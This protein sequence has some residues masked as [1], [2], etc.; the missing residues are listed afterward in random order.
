MRRSATWLV[1]FSGLAIALVGAVGA[2]PASA[3]PDRA[4]AS[5]V[6]VVGV[7]GLRWDDVSA[8]RTPTLTR[9]A[10]EGS[11]GSLSVRSAPGV[12]CGA[13]GWLTLGAG[14]YAAVEDPDAT[15]ASRGCRP[16]RP[17]PVTERDGAAKVVTMPLLRRVNDKLRFGAE[18]GLLGN[19]V[20]C[21][22]A[23]GPGAALAM[24]SED[25]VV[26][27]YAA[28]LPADPGP[29]LAHCPLAAVDLGA[30][31]ERGADRERALAGFDAALAKVDDARPD[32]SVL[33]VAGVA[34][35]DASQPRLHV[36]VATGDGFRGGWLH[37]SS[38]R[39]DPYLQLSDLAP[40]VLELLGEEVP[41]SLAGRPLTGG[42][43][44]RPEDFAD[45]TRELVDTDAAAVGQRDVLGPFFAGLGV[46]TLIGYGGLLWLLLR[47][48]R[49]QPYSPVL[50]RRFGIAA[51]GLAAV[52]GATFLANLVPWWRSSQPELAISALVVAF[53][54][55]TVAIG[56]AGPWR[57]A[58][59]R[60]GAGRGGRHRGGHADRRADRRDAADQQPARVQPAGRRA[61]RRLRQHRVRR[62]RRRRDAADRAA[63]LRSVTAGGA[64]HRGR[65]R[66]PD[67]RGG[68]HAGVGSRLRRRADV[69]AGVRG[70]RA[71]GGAVPDQRDPAPA[72]GRR[73][74]AAGRRDRRGRLPAGRPSRAATSAGSSPRCWTA[75]PAPRSIASS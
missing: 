46:A 47:R 27:D 58:P 42:G 61:V 73:R 44:G 35:T 50:L 16:R 70:A 43:A 18:P 49:G 33:I 12:T 52:P 22:A 68:R 72:R 59:R 60:P 19:T 4:R 30:L 24:A 69:R 62:V 23:V 32:G 11:V 71:V 26:D 53:A 51:V 65:D 9:L 8:A 57:S 13:E 45:A 38:T 28:K 5:H 6:V 31:P 21:T 36:A 2:A 75:R 17:P 66:H 54:A 3:S 15:K 7:A 41:E 29:L 56:Y 10:R 20:R 64:R 74:R 14:T 55:V 63:R 67:D 39:R 37:S 48:R 34:E 1:A 40:T 25:G